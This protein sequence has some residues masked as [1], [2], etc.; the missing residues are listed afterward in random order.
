MAISTDAAYNAAARTILHKVDIYM[1][2]VGATPL[3]LT[4]DNYIISSSLLEEATSGDT[5]FDSVTS[6]ELVLN[7]NNKDNLFTPTNHNSPYYG[8]MKR[9][10]KV[11]PYFKANENDDWSSLGEFYVTS[12]AASTTSSTVTVTADDKLYNIF[13]QDALDLP[14]KPQKRVQDVYTDFFA[15][16]GITPVIDNTLTESLVEFFDE[17]GNKKFLSTLSTAFLCTC[18]CAHNGQ[19]VIKKL[20]T[21]Q[22]LR[23]TI[24]DADQIKSVDVKLSVS[25]D[26]DSAYLKYYV[27]QE[28]AEESILNI[29]EVLLLENTN[30]LVYTLDNKPLLK[31]KSVSLTNDKALLKLS[32]IK[33]TSK[34]ISLVISNVEPPINTKMNVNGVYINKISYEI[35]EQKDNPL[36]VDNVYIQ[37]TQ[38]A[39]AFKS[40]MDTFASNLTPIIQVSLRGNPNFEIGDKIHAVSTRYGIDFTG[41]IMRQQ[42]D[43]NGGLKCVITLLNSSLV[44]V[45]S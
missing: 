10:V 38:R 30:S 22:A 12:W 41:I 16:F 33:C 11:I 3:S 7:L 20:T 9:G 29:N 42:F 5:P 39:L 35:G 43:Y 45:I 21:A 34:T 28:S 1:G 44:E 6:N 40:I 17:L 2:G 18:T 23:A 25:S 37:D 8:K 15:F 31:L 26:Y 14:V 19:V 32:S 13:S 27:P 4:K 24:T 36:S